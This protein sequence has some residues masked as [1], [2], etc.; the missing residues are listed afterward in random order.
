VGPS[1]EVIDEQTRRALFIDIH[2]D[3]H[4]VAA[5]TVTRVPDAIGDLIYPLNG[6]LTSAELAALKELK[7]SEAARSG[8]QKLIIEASSTV[9]FRFFELLDGVAD[10]TTGNFSPWLGVSLAAKSSQDEPMLHDELYD[11][12]WNY[13]ETV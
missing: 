13:K 10:P 4:D 6:E 11:S 12:W 5:K 7:L 8:L 9:M 3:I 1:A 2:R